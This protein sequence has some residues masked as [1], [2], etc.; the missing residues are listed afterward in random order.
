MVPTRVWTMGTPASAAAWRMPSVRR[1][2]RATNVS[3][4]PGSRRTRRVAM[5]ALM[6]SGLPERV[7]AWYMAPT[8]ATCSMISREPAYAPT[9]SPPPMT[10]PRVVMSGRTLYS[11]CAPPRW[12]RKPVI[13]SSKMSSAP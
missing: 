10:L 4:T 11:A 6:A 7:P 3:H 2:A 12:T 9:G 8:G 13:T 5:P 1:S